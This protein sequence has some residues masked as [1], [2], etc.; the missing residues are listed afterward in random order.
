M[1]I[2]VSVDYEGD[3]LRKENVESF[4]VFRETLPE[5]PIVHFLNPSYF[6]GSAK[7]K[8]ARDKIK[9][10]LREGDELG[11][12]IH[13]HRKL[14]EESGVNFNDKSTSYFSPPGYQFRVDNPEVE[15]WDVALEFSYERDDLMKIISTGKA[16]LER[17]GFQI[18]KSFRAGGW[19]AGPNVLWAAASAGFEIDSSAVPKMWIDEFIKLNPDSPFLPNCRALSAY[20]GGLWPEITKQSKPYPLEFDGKVIAEMPNT[21][22]LA[23]YVTADQMYKHISDVG[24]SYVQIGFHQES[25]S[26]FVERVLQAIS[27]AKESKINMEFV[28]LSNAAT[29]AVRE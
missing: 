18:G 3:S 23:D 25:A 22:C 16:I 6:L 24:P 8:K 4:Q 14:I 29:S 1:Q 20:V 28:T 19:M 21:G 7:D 26:L 11:L 2:V 5:V 17:H 10:L 15:G 12:H 9:S 27:R 13:G